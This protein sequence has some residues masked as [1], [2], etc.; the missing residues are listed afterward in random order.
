MS[1][2]L[3]NIVH[4]LETGSG[5][6]LLRLLPWALLTILI[7]VGYNLRSYRNFTTQEA[8]DQAQLAR[9]IAEGRGYTTK[10]VRPF[11]MF[12]LQ[13]QNRERLESL[14][15]EQKADLCQVKK[16]HPDI[17]NPPVYPLVLAALMKTGLL[18][19]TA[20]TTVPR[21]FWFSGSSFVRYQPDFLISFFNQLLLGV[22]VVATF[23]LA[24]RLFDLPVAFMSGIL[25]LAME[26]LWRFSVSGLS[27]ILLLLQFMGLIWALVSFE[28]RVKEAVPSAA[29]LIWTAALIGVLLGVGMLT[30]YAYGVLLLPVLIFLLAFGGRW[31]GVA[32]AVALVAFA[33]VV[34]PWIVRNVQLCGEPFGTAGY[35]PV[36]ASAIFPADKLE[37][38]MAP[39]LSKGGLTPIWWKF[40]GNL[41]GILLQEVPMIGGGFT[42]AFFLVG[43]MIPFRNQSLSRLRYFVLIALTMFMAA[44]AIG[45]TN[46][47]DESP[48][49]NSEN[50][51]I[52]LV[53]LV[54]I[55]G[56]GF[57]FTLLDQIQLPFRELR[58]AVVTV[59]CLIVS[60]PMVFTFLPP[61][62]SPV[63]FP[64]Y[65]PPDIQKVS[66]WMG[67]NELVMSD[68]P[69]AVAWYGNR[70]SV[71]RTTDA[72]EQF[73][74]INDYI[75][76]VGALYLTPRS[77]DAKF[78][79][80]WARGGTEFSWGQ[81][82]VQSLLREELPP[83]FPL[84]KSYRMSEQ[85]FLS[86]WER[87]AKPTSPDANL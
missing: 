57:F 30:R 18:P 86:N 58:Y 51:L 29:R 83:R 42:F 13:R 10:F 55:Y 49:I 16:D 68:V 84:M 54:V 15:P 60:L 45:R 41:R 64:P 1:L 87:W 85:L 6:A 81:I 12:L 4:K 34:T 56:V 72:N 46:L 66:G 50:L 76:P 20:D 21:A 2:W 47:S 19:D 77:L 53:P 48:G 28:A 61:K 35:A 8:M 67:E 43:L 73:F 44:Q 80:Q 79:S 69:W 59:F 17:S 65:F 52:L 70:Q 3:Q 24:R 62:T 40:Y 5:A 82:V 39:D 37:R 33:L 31:R 74:A 26:P 11:S 22:L 23:Q 32:T 25:V 38:S 36:E 9:N 71:L 14:T 27:T 75:K 78:L 63:S 7:V